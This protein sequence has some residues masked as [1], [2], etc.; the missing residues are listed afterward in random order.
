MD[1]CT[2]FPEGWWATCCQAHDLAYIN[3]I[4]K[5]LADSQLLSCVA[6]SANGSVMAAVSFA[7]AGLMYVGVRLFGR[8]YYTNA[9]A[10][11]EHIND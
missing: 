10:N 1:Y 9:K 5:A 11:K 4:G 6:D 8:K 7:V 3:Q 2:W